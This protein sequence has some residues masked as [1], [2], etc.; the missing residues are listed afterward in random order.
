MLAPDCFAGKSNGLDIRLG[1]INFQLFIQFANQCSFW[2]LPCLNLSSR[3]LPETSHRLSF[4]TFL[5]QN[6]A[7]LID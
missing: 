2:R 5:H 3:E 4:R 1:N 6:S 7:I